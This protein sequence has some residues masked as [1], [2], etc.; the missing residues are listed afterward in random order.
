MARRLVFTKPGLV[1]IEEFEPPKVD[2]GMVG[3]RSLC[4]LMSTGTETIVLNRRFA[5]GS[6]WDAWVKYPFHPGYAMIGE[7]VETG[8]GVN[9]LKVGDRVAMRAPHA[10]FH[11]LNESLCYPVPAQL[12]L[13]QVAWFALAKIAFMGAKAARFALGDDVL[14]VGAGPIGQMAT[15][16]ATAAGS[17]TIIVVDMIDSRL[18]MAKR[19]GATCTLAKPIEECRKDIEAAN[20]G[21]LPNLVID[22]TG[23]AEVFAA[24]LRVTNTT[25]RLVILGDTGH[26]QEQHLT[27]DVIVK[28][29]TIVGAHDAHETDRWTMRRIHRLFIN[30]AVSGRFNLDGLN[31]HEF[32]PEECKAAYELATYCRGETMGIVFDWSRS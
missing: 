23:N 5:V 22:S 28:G 8:A 7:V 4:S 1:E 29:L 20:H 15:R 26:P 16:W 11:V 19:G 9:E 14:I 6:H 17:E 30:L 13:K 2:K 27:S 3:V 24:A 21:E 10:S 31:T 25:G 18:E 32:A 12:D